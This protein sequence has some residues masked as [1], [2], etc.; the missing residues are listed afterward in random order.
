MSLDY[1]VVAQANLHKKKECNVDLS[2]YASFLTKSH[3]I[4]TKNKVVL[5]MKAYNKKY[6]YKQ[7]KNGSIINT[8][9]SML[10]ESTSSSMSIQGQT[11]RSQSSPPRASGQSLQQQS[12]ASSSQTLGTQLA[13]TQNLNSARKSVSKDPLL[14]ERLKFRKHIHSYFKWGLAG[15]IV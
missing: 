6:S 9:G 15:I 4:N 8:S 11:G 7:S 14:Q 12:L 2:L 3:H 13:N 1:I 5:G 10:A